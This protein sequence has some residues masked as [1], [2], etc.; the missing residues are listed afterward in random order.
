MRSEMKSSATRS[1]ALLLSASIN[2]D[3]PR[4]KARSGTRTLFVDR[5]SMRPGSAEEG[6]AVTRDDGTPLGAGDLAFGV[7]RATGA[8]VT[9]GKDDSEFVV[10]V[11]V[12]RR[13]TVE[14]S[15]AGRS[16]S[17]GCVAKR[18]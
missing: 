13:E 1:N 15:M 14:L 11:S 9:G 18:S 16:M 7:A 4:K 12:S 2:A 10:D 8:C 6:D 3:T 5:R 17:P